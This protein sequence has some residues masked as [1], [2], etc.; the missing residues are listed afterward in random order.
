VNDAIDILGS[1]PDDRGIG[2]VTGMDDGTQPLEWSRIAA[3]AGNR[4][5]LPTTGSTGLGYL[6]PNEARGTG[7]QKT[8]RHLLVFV[9]MATFG[10]IQFSV[11][12]FQCS[13]PWS[14]PCWKLNTEH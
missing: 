7:D 6:P 13:V 12:S 11:F 2:Q 1:L 5:H 10:K 3:E 4:A 14:E 9:A 8:L